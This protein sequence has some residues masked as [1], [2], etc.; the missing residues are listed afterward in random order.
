VTLGLPFS[1]SLRKEEPTMRLFGVSLGEGKTKVG[2]VFTFSLPSHTTCP[3]AS[4]WCLK[5][6][7]AH[8]YEKLRPVCLRAYQRNLVLSQ[9][10]D[11]FVRLVV[12]V[13]PRILT[14]MRIHV[15]GG[16]YSPQYIQSWYRICLAFPQTRFWSYSRSW[17]VPELLPSLEQLRALGNVEIFAST[18]P[19]MPLPSKGWRVAFIETDSRAR[20]MRCSEQT[21][22][23]E[24][25]LAC[26]YC[27][28]RDKGDVIFKVH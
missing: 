8:R 14:C 13:L 28:S 4:P 22:Q 23:Q 6:C 26:G 19:T 21:E 16:L 18:D 17:V 25:C 10:S 20:G 7:Y 3:G 11:E 9:R 5:H 12:G 27:F 1:F 15:S 2:D 24:S